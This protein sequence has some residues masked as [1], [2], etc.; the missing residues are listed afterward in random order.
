MEFQVGETHAGYEFLDVLKRTK[1]GI[2]FKVRNTLVG[3]VEALRTI[4]E[5]SDDKEQTDRFL[6]EM[7]VHAGLVHP[8]IV[9]L[10]N[11]AAVDNQL[12]LTTEL[13]EGQ[14]VADRLASGPLAWEEAVNITIQ[15]L[16]ALG[17]AHYQGIVHRDLSPENITIG[18]GGLVKLGNFTLAKPQA[19]PKLTQVGIPI[20]NLKYISPEQI[21]ALGN[22]D[23]R[24]DLY[25]LGMVLYEMLAG[26]PA[27]VAE[28]DFDLMAAQ[29]A[30]PPMPPSQ[31][32]NALP[33]EFDAVLLKALA[34]NP[35][36]RYQTA[37]EFD[38]ALR[39]AG[40]AVLA[41]RPAV[42]PPAAMAVAPTPRAAE[43]SV[44]QEDLRPHLVPKP[45][46]DTP[47]DPEFVIGTGGP[48][49]SREQIILA[50]AAGACTGVA[51]AVF[52]L[53]MK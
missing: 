23:G 1:S 24:S 6:R 47:P 46:P 27:F 48:A 4:P 26:R 38:H 11:A 10:F 32:N 34:K 3:R 13:V 45:A 9:T 20:G 30:A 15:I 39:I 31:I 33:K 8:N 44:R 19:S 14:T 41:R 35:A 36:D 42:A 18:K 16:A 25:S 2:E 50:S 12:V 28:S 29:V 7:R 37:A 5:G 21:K 49:L 17:Y 22:V 40:D 51:L 53:V 52:W 43:P